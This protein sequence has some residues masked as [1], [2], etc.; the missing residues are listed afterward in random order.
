MDGINSGLGMG[1]GGLA[2]GVEVVNK[3]IGNLGSKGRGDTK[4]RLRLEVFVEGCHKN[5][6]DN[7]AEYITL[8]HTSPSVDGL[9]GYTIN[10]EDGNTVCIP[11]V[12]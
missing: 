9:R 7:T 10:V 4:V 3:G 6:E 8:S 12:K 5:A 2:K 1:R 11:V